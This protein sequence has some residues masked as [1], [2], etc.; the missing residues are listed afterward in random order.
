MRKCKDKRMYEPHVQVLKYILDLDQDPFCSFV[1]PDCTR[2]NLINLDR[3][4]YS[5]TGIR[6]IDETYMWQ[7]IEVDGKL[8]ITSPLYIETITEYNKY[9]KH[10][11]KEMAINYE[12]GDLKPVDFKEAN[13][14]LQGSDTDMEP[15]KVYNN[16]TMSVSCWKITFRDV[17]R[18]LFNPKKRYIWMGVKAGQSQPPVWLT[19][20]YP[21]K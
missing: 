13:R 16:G 11:S 4:D 1:L 21:F 9:L 7:D 6:V 18:L 17:L 12:I 2:N 20:R 15:L 14:L 10:I 3:V 5:I 19:T 8:H